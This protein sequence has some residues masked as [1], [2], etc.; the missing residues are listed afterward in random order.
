MGQP[1]LILTKGAM[2]EMIEAES[3]VYVTVSDKYVQLK[4]TDHRILNV[5]SS[6]RQFERDLSPAL[7][8]RIHK[9]F[10]VCI[11]HIRFVDTEITMKTGDQL[12]LSREY[13]EQFLSNFCVF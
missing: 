6:L 8:L 4:L 1:F 2:H 12:P 7:F 5:R 3:I 13:K 9:R 11:R 10:I